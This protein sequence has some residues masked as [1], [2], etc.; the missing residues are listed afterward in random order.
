MG[1]TRT[2]ARRF[3][4][5]NMIP[6]NELASPGYRLAQLGTEYL[7]YLPQGKQ[8][9]V[10]LSSARGRLSAHWI[11]PRDAKF[12]TLFTTDGGG[13]RDFT[14]PNDGDWLFYLKASGR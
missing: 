11:H 9:R 8:A 12:G 1:Y 2:V 5:A 13:P 3:S 4:I 7:V 6:R 10:D 14:P